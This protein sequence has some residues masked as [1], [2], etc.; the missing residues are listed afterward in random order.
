MSNYINEMD[1]LFSGSQEEGT[2]NQSITS[3]L[4]NTPVTCNLNCNNDEIIEQMIHESEVEHEV[5]IIM[6]EQKLECIGHELVNQVYDVAKTTD[7][8][9]TS[10]VKVSIEYDLKQD[11]ILS[12]Q[13]Q[14]LEVVVP[15]IITS[16][17]E[18]D[19]FLDGVDFKSNCFRRMDE[20]REKKEK[21]Y[22]VEKVEERIDF[23]EYGELADIFED[24]HKKKVENY[25][26]ELDRVKKLKEAD[27]QSEKHLKDL[28]K[29]K[30]ADDRL[31]KKIEATFKKLQL[32]LSNQGHYA[33]VIGY[34]DSQTLIKLSIPAP[35]H[36][37]VDNRGQI[38]ITARFI[39][40][41]ATKNAFYCYKSGKYQMYA[42]LG[43][44]RGGKYVKI[45]ETDTQEEMWNFI[46]L[47]DKERRFGF[48]FKKFQPLD[49]SMYY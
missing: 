47:K 5:K 48:H 6:E 33:S 31:N 12:E 46:I 42:N 18:I 17:E 21:R 9:D 44:H 7:Q 4:I 49:L 20:E 40:L 43:V 45:H 14:S 23:S 34:N 22:Y 30:L 26:Q 27:K 41:S 37:L 11:T 1:Q 8:F 15:R 38:I 16:D 3:A 39:E 10:R 25:K 32:R 2:L 29:K 24:E 28:Q 36:R 19:W 13:D 35:Y